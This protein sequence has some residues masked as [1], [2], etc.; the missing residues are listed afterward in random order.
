ML[1]TWT[2]IFE[3]GGRLRPGLNDTDHMQKRRHPTFVI[4]TRTTGLSWTRTY[5]IVSDSGMRRTLKVL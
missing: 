3:H 2:Y 5:V 1:P 4:A